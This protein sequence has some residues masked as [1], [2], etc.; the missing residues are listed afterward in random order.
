MLRACIFTKPFRS[1]TLR[2]LAI[3]TPLAIAVLL[4]LPVRP[5][6]AVTNT[7][8]ND[9][10]K[11]GTDID[12]ASPQY[13]ENNGFIGNDAD[14]DMDLESAWFQGGTGGLNPVAAN[15][16][17]RGT[18]GTTSASWTTYI[19]PEANPVNLAAEGDS[20]KVTWNFTLTGI[21]A[22]NTSQGF[23]V[24]LVDTPSGKRLTGDGTPG[25]AAFKGNAMFMNMSP[26]LGNSGSFRLMRRGLSTD[27]DD[28]LMATSSFW[29]ALGTSGS[30]SGRHGY[31]AATPYSFTWQITR[32]ASAGLDHVVRMSGGTLDDD[33]LAEVVFTDTTPVDAGTNSNGSFTFD[34]FAVRP[35]S[36]S[37]NN[38]MPP[39]AGLTAD[40]FDTSLFKV[41]Y[42]T[43]SGPPV[44]PGDFNGD[45]KVDASDYVVW[46][47][48]INT[49]VKYDEWR[50]NFGVGAGAGAALGAGSVPEPGTMILVVAAAVGALGVRRRSQ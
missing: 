40:Q 41:E 46:R 14:A 3:T 7:L 8:V 36:G 27:P 20:V 42:T 29:T 17:Q 38:A 22:G 31:D 11:D 35:S 21:N 45:L 47:E 13:A 44:Q 28:D 49:Q 30:T 26:T 43:S 48:T 32:N 10:W 23:R 1:H 25:D 6:V 9:T 4:A 12:P 2:Y 37:L 16:P 19:T 24:A 33:G 39:A 34:T 5:A 15:G 50:A 18:V